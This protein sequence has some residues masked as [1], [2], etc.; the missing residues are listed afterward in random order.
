[1]SSDLL[2]IGSSGVLAQ[3]KLLWT[4]SNNITNINTQGY[5]RQSTILYTNGT[6]L[7]V[8]MSQTNRLL[9]LY[10][11]AEVRRDTSEFKY[12]QSAY[13]QLA[14]TDQLLSD[15]SNS[16]S[17]SLNSYFKAFQAANESPNTDASRE[18]LMSQIKAINNRFQTIS[19]SLNKQYSTINNKVEGEVKSINDLLAGVNELNQQIAKSGGNTDGTELNL[20]DQRDELIR[21]LSEKMDIRTVAQ[22]NGTVLVNLSTGQSLVLAGGA[23]S[24]S[25]TQGNPDATQTGLQLT[26]GSSKAT[27]NTAVGGSLGGLYEARAGLEP[28]QRELGQ[29]AVALSDA[30]NSQNKLGMTLNNQLGSD[31]F[32][33]P[34]SKGLANANNSGSGAISVAFM[35]GKGSEVTPNDFEVK[36]TAGNTFEVYML[37]GDTKSLVTSGSTP[38][39][40]FQM[41]DYGIEFTVSG[42]PAAGDSLL[43]QPTRDAAANIGI[44]VSRGEDIALAASVKTSAAASNYGSAKIS[45]AGVYNTGAGSDFTASALQTSAPHTVKIDS[46]GNYEVYDGSSPAVLLGVAPAASKG[47]DL[48]ANMEL[49]LGGPK[50]YPDVKVQPGFD[51]NV[52]GVAKANDE[53]SIDFNT[54]GF[55]DNYNGLALANL[56]TQDLVRKGNST[57]ADNKMTFNEGFSATLSTLGSKVSSLKTNADAAEAKQSQSLDRFNSEAGVNM[58]EEAANLVRFQ[59][60]YAAS[61]QIISTARAIFD[62]L[63][64]A[65]R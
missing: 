50:S 36:F 58:D 9:D 55:S 53:F 39:A 35:A 1:M 4:T 33:L 12:Y 65:A 61:A 18:S 14:V 28:V 17:T 38:P 57:A 43:L 11:Q 7:G 41:P 13:N 42:T 21:Q 22:S 52:S 29:L 3:Q 10:A 23:A 8:G 25:V 34:T 31:L 16:I 56:Q 2:S 47:Q 37:D 19:G 59:Q 5:T 54:N 26:I 6:G 62:T 64:G 40:L 51:V 30:M 15:S 63:L 46:A 45:L 60:A 44:A 48:F 24:L 49:P 20:V 27:L 32:T